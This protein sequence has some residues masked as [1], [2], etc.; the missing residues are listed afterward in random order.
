MANGYRFKF[1]Q[2]LKEN[3][4]E[5]TL[6]FTSDVYSG[7]S[8][9]YSEQEQAWRPANEY[10]NSAMSEVNWNNVINKL[11]EI[12]VYSVING[13]ESQM[14]VLGKITSQ[15]YRIENNLGLYE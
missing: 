10:L 2:I 7:I 1:R 13:I 8:T 15:E 6:N 4:Q 5:T 3:G 11:T 12:T 9:V 14:Y